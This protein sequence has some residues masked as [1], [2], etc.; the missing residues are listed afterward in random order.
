MSSVIGNGD[1]GRERLAALLNAVMVVGAE[2]EL[3][4][5]LQRIVEAATELADCKYAALGVVGKQYANAAGVG[6]TEKVLVEFITEGLTDEQRVA[7]GALPHSDGILGVLVR[8]PRALRLDDLSTHPASVGFPPNHPPMGSFLGVPIRIRGH[9]FGN[10]YLTQK[11]GGSFTEADEAD[12]LTLAAAAGVA[13]EN[14]RLYDDARRAGDWQRATKDINRALLA[15]GDP[16]DALALVAREARRLAQADIAA[17]GFTDPGGNLVVEICD[18]EG[19][20]DLIGRPFPAAQPHLLVPLSWQS[21]SAALYVSRMATTEGFD[22]G[23]VAALRAFAD[24]AVLALELAAARRSEEEV[25][26][27]QDRDRIARDLHDTVIQ[28]LFA[29]GMRLDAVSRGL[30]EV[31]ATRV[32]GVVDELDTVI[33]ELRTAIYSLQSEQ[34]H[35]TLSWG[36]RLGDVVSQLGAILGFSPEFTIA[37]P[38][39]ADV[40][41][42][43]ADDAV[44]VVREALSNVAKHSDASAAMVAVEVTDKRFR[45]KIRD[46]GR[47][48]STSVSRRSGLAN[49]E[50]RAQMHGGHFS[51]RSGVRDS[52][53]R[54]WSTVLYWD[55]PLTLIE[56]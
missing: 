27:L 56:A 54:R 2:L 6:E 21:Q 46:D 55:V 39:D 23:M 28:R 33:T 44:A 40:P 16:A 4:A 15:G 20:R 51:I 17:I 18:G 47:G 3:D 34:T 37:D 35:D 31:I 50:T 36:S 7:I 8:D 53:G 24:Q 25:L 1:D 9:V 32:G 43:V 22:P 48:I 45:I 13:I 42:R 38:N 14:A 19:S 41:V 5:V 12:V 10:L 49:L 11:R 52:Y 29:A 26:V 30:P